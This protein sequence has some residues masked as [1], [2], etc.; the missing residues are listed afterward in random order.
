M[1][2]KNQEARYQDINNTILRQEQEIMPTY[3]GKDSQT[4]ENTEEIGDQ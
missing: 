3:Q 1:Q 4:M 2:N